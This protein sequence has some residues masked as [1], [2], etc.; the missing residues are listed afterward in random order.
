MEYRVQSGICIV[1]QLQ[2]T[3]AQEALDLLMFARYECQ[4]KKIVIKKE[5]LDEEFFRLASGL[6][7]EILQ[8]YVN[9]GGKMAV[10]GDFSRYNSKA[11]ADF[12]LECNKG[13]DFF[14]VA[15]ED[16]A[17]HRLL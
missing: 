4:T 1:D 10:Y 12:I 17:I 9:Y 7:G 5:C 2:I 16:E 6:A 15:T 8:K 11:L 13:K 3:D 14:F